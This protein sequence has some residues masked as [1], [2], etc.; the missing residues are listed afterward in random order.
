[1]ELNVNESD[2]I[3]YCE[4]IFNKR[5]EQLTDEEKSQ[6]IDDIKSGRFGEILWKAFLYLNEECM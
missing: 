4:I 5:P 3:T 6:L 2:L 1:M